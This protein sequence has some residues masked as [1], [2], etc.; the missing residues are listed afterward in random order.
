MKL[1]KFNFFGRGLKLRIAV[2]IACQMAFVLFGY[3]QGVFSGIIGNE[4]FVA[5][6]NNPNPGLEGIIV[7]IYNLGCFTGCI[8]AFIFCEKTGRRLVMWIAMCWIIVSIL[9]NVISHRSAKPRH[10]SKWARPPA[11]IFLGGGGDRGK[12]G[13]L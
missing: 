2:T 9:L 6:F 8:L 3:D 4:S 7:S 10:P 5:T 12:S 13:N 1:P 11:I